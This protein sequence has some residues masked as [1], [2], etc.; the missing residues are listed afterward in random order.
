MAQTINIANIKVGMNVEGGEFTRGEIRSLSSA[1]K[2]SE[3]PADKFFDQMKL[4]DRALKEGAINAQQFAQAEEHLAKKFGVLTYAMEQQIQ[5]EKKLAQ[6]EKA[7]SDAAKVLADEE[8][9]LARIVESSHTPTQRMAQDIAF[10]DKQYQAGKIDA[11]QYNASVDMLAKK[12]GLAAIYAE[13]Q[14]ANEK[15]LGDIVKRVTAETNQLAAAEQAAADKAR[16][17]AAAK[18]ADIA[19][20]Q[21]AATQANQQTIGQLKSIALQYVGIAA[22]FQAVKKSVSLATELEST[23]IAF[24]VMTGSASKAETLIKQFKRLDVESPLNYTDFA[25][26]GKVLMQFGVNASEV[27]TTMNRLAA[28]SLGNSE[29]FQRLSL[30]FGQVQAN[31]RLMGQEVLQMV[32]SGF[33][34]LQEISRTTGISMVELKKRMEDGQISA[35]MVAMAFKTATEEGGLFAGMN[36]RLS[37]SMAGQFAKMEGDIKAAAISL[38]NDLMPLIKE[39]VGLIRSGFGTSESGERGPFAANIKGISDSYTSLFAGVGAGFQT[40]GERLSKGDVVFGTGEAMMAAFNGVLDKSQEIKDAELDREAA[41]IRAANQESEIAQKK[42][43]QVAE[44]K[45]LAEAEMERSRAD[46]ERLDKLKAETEFQKKAGDELWSMRDR[47]NKLTLGED[48]ARR[49]K[50]AREGYK[51]IDIE[52][53]DAMLKLIGAEEDRKKAMEESQ[54]IEKEM[55]SDKQKAVDEIRRLQGLYDQ[56]SVDQKTGTMGQANLAKQ[57][58]IRQR[59]GESQ[60]TEDIAKNLAP[61][62]KAGSKEAAAFLL[63]QNADAAE[64]AERK[65]WQADLLNETRRAN[66][67]AKEAPRIQFAR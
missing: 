46:K 61:A 67:M 19:K 29:Q 42:Q 52:R 66:D 39:T 38:G 59:F 51:Q 60:K 49:Q 20:A 37:Q 43:E 33:N 41:L 53:Y 34:P 13:K 26:A 58:Q 16:A 4:L 30:A 57:E 48:E 25:N 64:K 56:L 7:A 11:N 5:T 24:E 6:T 3:A 50:Q 12:H 65:K 22:A 55:V 63:Q 45:K 18:Q 31:G 23:K 28:V 14:A 36:E 47:L 27:S 8:A 1:L 10:L 2:Q 40:L 62:L 17:L 21:A 9:R 44:A 35:Q 15:I 54:A 32:N